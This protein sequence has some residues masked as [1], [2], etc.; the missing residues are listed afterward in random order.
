MEVKCLDVNSKEILASFS[1]DLFIP[2][3]KEI[4]FD[5]SVQ[6]LNIN[7]WSAEIPNLYLLIL[8]LTDKLTNSTE[9]VSS[10]IGFRNIE[11]KYGQMLINNKPIIIKGVNR[12]EHD[13]IMGRTVSEELMIKDIK[14]MKKLFIK[15]KRAIVS[16]CLK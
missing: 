5:S 8:S 14:L 13:P 11:I 9:F 10:K 1:K 16:K 3:L 6:I 7:P 15:V 2:S 4:T 12:H